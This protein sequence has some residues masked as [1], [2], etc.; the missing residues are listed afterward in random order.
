M[1]YA[2]SILMSC[3]F[4][5][6]ALGQNAGVKINSGFSSIDG[7]VFEAGFGVYVVVNDFS[8]KAEVL[9][10]FDYNKAN[11]FYRED[12][13]S[14]YERFYFTAAGLYVFPVSA[15][16]KFKPGLAFSHENMRVIENGIVS[17]WVSTY[18]AKHLGI[19]ISRLRN[20]LPRH[21]HA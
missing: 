7:P 2:L 11:E 9:F 21:G 12:Y 18:Y 6:P 1:K 10:S 5:L 19:G 14:N 16:L 17:N 4:L 15:N 20:P 3:G 8:D 13:V